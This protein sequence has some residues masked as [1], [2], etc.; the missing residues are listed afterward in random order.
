MS[1]IYTNEHK[2]HV[3]CMINTSGHIRATHAAYIKGLITRNC[4]SAWDN[5]PIYWQNASIASG[6]SLNSDALNK[7]RSS[8]RSDETTAEKEKAFDV[9]EHW[10][11]TRVDCC[12][13]KLSDFKD[14][15][16][17]RKI[18]KL[19]KHFAFYEEN[20]LFARA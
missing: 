18:T 2:P 9:F 7:W 14:S 12:S 3:P 17:Q 13:F 5:G 10:K 6:W 20:L 4:S 1:F 8:R 11:S 19:T 16:N 15:P